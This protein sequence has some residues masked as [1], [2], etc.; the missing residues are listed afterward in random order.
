MATLGFRALC[1]TL[2]LCGPA[3]SALASLDDAEVLIQQE[4]R[5]HQE[6]PPHPTD[7]RH[8]HSAHPD[9]AAAAEAATCP[10]LPRP[11]HYPYDKYEGVYNGMTVQWS[12]SE[13]AEAAVRGRQGAYEQLAPLLRKLQKGKTLRIVVFGGSSTAGMHCE[14][15]TARFKESGGCSKTAGKPCMVHETIIAK[16]C[17][18]PRRFQHWLQ[19]A[20]PN[21]KIEL[22]NFAQ[23]AATSSSILVGSGIMMKAYNFDKND[24][25]ADIIFVDTLVNDVY[26]WQKDW[27]QDQK[28][29]MDMSTNAA[30]AFE[31]VVRTLHAL[32]PKAVIFPVLSGCNLCWSQGGGHRQVIDHYNLPRLDWGQFV[33][34]KQ[35]LWDGPDAHPNY[36]VHQSIADVLAA[37]WGSAWNQEC[38]SRFTRKVGH[39]DW[40]TSYFPPEALSTFQPCLDPR[41]AYDASVPET[42]KG[43]QLGEGWSLYEDRPGKPGWISERSGARIAFPLRFGKHPALVITWM[44]SYENMGYATV[45]LNNFKYHLDG[46]WTEGLHENV[47]LAHSRWLQVDRPRI[48]PMATEEMGVAGFSIFPWQNMTMVIEN[49]LDH[50]VKHPKMKILQVFTC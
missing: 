2:L 18:W 19:Y 46:L 43:V 39:L 50:T 13:F 3:A 25:G 33:A 8:S 41:S 47:T 7:R 16:E 6:T 20:F 34:W 42:T 29:T 28:R 35:N 5:R 27:G 24:R 32:Q 9:H 31:Q 38:Q 49:S 30:M 12:D 36:W 1:S 22:D 44:R 37:V 48:Q 23:G 14:Q 15:H 45:E 11:L 10:S 4:L 21:A 40:S 17:S 26:Q